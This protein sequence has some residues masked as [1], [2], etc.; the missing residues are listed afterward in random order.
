MND[1]AAAIGLANFNKAIKSIS[2]SKDNARYYMN[3]IED[4]DILPIKERYA[5]PSFWVFPIK[6]NDMNRLEKL[7]RELSAN[8][9]SHSRM[10]KWNNE[11]LCFKQEDIAKRNEWLF[12]PCGHW[13]TKRNRK[14]I[15]S[16]IN[17]G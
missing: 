5:H 8:N 14:L 4:K 9:I 15:T 3:N 17:K 2:I 13:V 1:I 16:L 10:W 7:E 12:I 11:H 6:F